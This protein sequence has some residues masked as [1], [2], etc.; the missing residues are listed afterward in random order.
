[1]ART[2]IGG[3]IH[4]N[5]DARSTPALLL[6]L[7]LWTAGGPSWAEESATA[8]P[9]VGGAAAGD[10]AAAAGSAVAGDST[11]APS[12][13][14]LP[15]PY[16]PYARAL[17]RLEASRASARAELENALAI[18]SLYAPALSLLSK[19]DFEDSRHE[20]AVRRLETTRGLAQRRGERLPTALLEGLALHYD[21]LD[22]PDLAAGILAGHPEAAR[23]T[24]STAVYLTLRS[25]QPEAADALA[26]AALKRNEKSAV[27]QNNFGIT[28][29]RAGDVEA[30]H[31]AFLA[32]LELDPSLPG[33]YYNLAILEKYYRL[34]DG[35]AT[36]W[37]ASY[38]ER[39]TADPDG[40][41]EEFGIP[42]ASTG[43]AGGNE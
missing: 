22:R 25:A 40:L 38:R 30:A 37:M 13:E 8:A 29:L 11:A 16:A 7:V 23:E 3:A 6:G 15:D 18:D 2:S 14:I 21:A 33:P 20:E 31:A 34:D 4:R 19:L 28:R 41:F 10:S 26:L 36:R 27:N 5:R 1:M 32:A 42:E 24:P 9:S 17:E 35:A 43:S 39:S 12:P